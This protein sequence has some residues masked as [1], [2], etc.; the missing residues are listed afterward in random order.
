MIMYLFR[1]LCACTNLQVFLLYHSILPNG[2]KRSLSLNQFLGRY[3]SIERMIAILLL[4]L[5]IV[6]FYSFRK[7]IKQK[8]REISC[9]RNLLTNEEEHLRIVLSS[10]GEGVIVSD[11]DG[12]VIFINDMASKITGW[13]NESAIGMLISDVFDI[14]D[15]YSLQQT[16]DLIKRIL[17]KGEK[18]ESSEQIVLKRKDGAERS[19]AYD[20]TPIRDKHGQIF[21]II[22]VFCDITE[23]LIKIK[24]IEYLGYHDELTGLGNRRYL[25]AKL[26]QFNQE[27]YLPLAVIIGDANGLKLIN[28]AFGH[29]IGDELLIRMAEAV[30]SACR[31]D[32]HDHIFRYGGDEFIVLLPNTS[33]TEAEKISNRIYQSCSEIQIGSIKFSMSLGWAVK[34]N[35]DDNL[36][37]IITAAENF[38]YRRKQ[39]DRTDLKGNVVQRIMDS[40]E[41]NVEG[42]KLHS[43]HVSEM[44]ER[45]ADELNLDTE[46]KEKCKKAGKY[47]DIGKSIIDKAILDKSEPLS[48][49]EWHIIRQ[50][51]ENGYRI[52]SIDSNYKDIALY[53]L[54]HHERWD[55]KGYPKGLKGEEIQF[56]SRIIAVCD[57]YDAMVS[58][59]PYHKAVSEDEAARE[60]I[61]HSGSQFDPDIAKVF[62]EKVLRRRWN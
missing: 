19:I 38:M 25:E 48:S 40:L 24:E 60:I 21:G 5:L 7:T 42:E 52:L 37:E 36:M 39:G 13:T 34:K 27:A 56:I 18:I 9:I 22:W 41:L 11:L 59:R 45:L 23:K 10:I 32:D 20:A 16:S 46:A 55:G 57:S 35:P 26:N 15:R 1:H 29:F 58:D 47:H 30:K 6:F 61:F 43:E 12:K 44:C 14:T 62:V 4:I 49:E 28:D 54:Q 33:E 53:V 2:E 17:T 3:F 8:N 31:S 51:S 50:H